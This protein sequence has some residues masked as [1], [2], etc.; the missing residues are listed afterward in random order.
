VLKY[1]VK[2]PGLNKIVYSSIR[3]K[4][5]T[6]F[7]GNMKDFIVG[8]AALDSAVEDLLSKMN[9]PCPV[10]Y[11]MTECAPLVSIT[12]WEYGTKKHSVG[13]LMSL[14]EAKVDS[15]DPKNIPGELLLRGECVM[16]GY[17]KNPEV[18]AEVIDED[19]WLHTGDLGRIDEDGYL[20]IVD[21]KKDLVIRGGFNIYPRDV[22]EILSQHHAVSEV[23]VIGIPDA[24]MGEELVACIVKESKKD[25]QEEELIAYCQEHLAKNKTPRKILFFDALPRNGVGKILKT[26]LRTAASERIIEQDY[27]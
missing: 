12:L 6:T 21:R 18:T 8:G 3:K 13:Q 9:F 16:M 15:P 20:Y 22:E 17:Y 26:H 11:G 7:G 27:K 25:I 19:G 23:A 24:S 1:A 2:I 14:L 5:I 4:L 10:G